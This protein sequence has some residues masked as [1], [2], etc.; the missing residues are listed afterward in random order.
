MAV[1]RLNLKVF[2]L[3]NDGYASIRTTQRNYFG[4]AYL[5]CDSATGLGFP[6]WS[7]LA[8]A[9]DIPWVEVGPLGLQDEYVTELLDATGPALFIVKVDPE[10]TY[11]PK[12]TSRVA[13]DGSMV[14][15]P[16][17]RMSPDLP[18]DVAAEVFRFG[19]VASP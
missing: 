16:I 2:L 19:P 17:H 5:G 3:D 13:E 9:F 7:K 1:Q 14:S 12:V 10:Q 4:G 15:N 11:F 18:D 8:D 6:S